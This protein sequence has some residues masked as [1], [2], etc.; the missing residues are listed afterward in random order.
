MPVVSVTPTISTGAYASGDVIGGIMTVEG[1]LGM[2][3]L[4]VHIGVFDADG[5]GVQLDFFLFKAA[6]TGTYTDNAAFAIDAADQDNWIGVTS[7]YASDYVAAGAD[8]VATKE[9][10]NIVLERGA[11][12]VTALDVV[13]VIRSAT[14]FTTTSDLRFDFGYLY[15]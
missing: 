3:G 4:L 6:L 14:T 10:I 7:I 15:T 11:N 2:R 1:A 13:C 5:E 9:P 8:K 12:G